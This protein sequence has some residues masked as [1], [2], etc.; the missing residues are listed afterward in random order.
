MVN[1]WQR[2]SFQLADDFQRGHNPKEFQ[3]SRSKTKLFCFSIFLIKMGLLNYKYYDSP[4]GE[5][6]YH[7][8]FYMSKHAAF[9]GEY[10]VLI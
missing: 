3:I 7:K 5:E 1:K 4:E 2:K 8:L 6:C 10:Q 9:I